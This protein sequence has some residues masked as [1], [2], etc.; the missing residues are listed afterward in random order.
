MNDRAE[1]RC[2]VRERGAGDLATVAESDVELALALGVGRRRDGV[3]FVGES[4]GVERRE[5]D[6]ER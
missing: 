1:P 2:R 5:A 4:A 6:C 3:P